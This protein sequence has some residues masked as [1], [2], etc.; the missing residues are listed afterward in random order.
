MLTFILICGI[1]YKLERS[2][3]VDSELVPSR[4]KATFVVHSN[5]L[6]VKTS[7]SF[8]PNQLKLFF[9]L[10][11]QIPREAQTIPV[12]TA[13][14]DTIMKLLAW[15]SNTDT[16]PRAYV[17]KLLEDLSA[18]LIYVIDK[19]SN[20]YLMTWFDYIKLNEDGK[21]FNFKLKELLAPFLLRLTRNFTQF[22]LAYLLEFKS[23]HTIRLYDYLQGIRFRQTVSL[24][25]D[26]FRNIMSLKIYSENGD[27]VGD[28]Y[29][30]YDS[31]VKRILRPSVDEI[32]SKSDIKVSYKPVK[33][34]HDRRKIDGIQFVIEKKKNPPVYDYALP[35][36]VVETKVD[37]PLFDDTLDAIVERI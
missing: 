15:D 10:L 30:S 29:P 27:V 18:K 23:A 17:Q 8:T 33:S 21:H 28:K 2:C 3:Q 19:K 36:A 35:D 26:E 14:I 37:A 24:T 20:L 4:Q 25:L 5:D 7:N 11:S 1:M 9:F 6:I 12:I 34:R 32:N 13:D 31:I 16:G 22:Q